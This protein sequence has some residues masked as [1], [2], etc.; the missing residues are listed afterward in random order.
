MIAIT[1][2]KVQAWLDKHDYKPVTD[3][4]LKGS[5][6][7]DID[8]RT[9]ATQVEGRQRSR[10][11]LPQWYAERH[12]LIWPARISLEQCSSEAT[13]RFK[14]SLVGGNRFADLTGGM[15]VDAFYLSQSF[16]EGYYV[17]K[18]PELFDITRHNLQSLEADVSYY[19]ADGIV[20]LSKQQEGFDWLY[21]DPARR[22][23]H[24]QKVI[25]LQDYSPDI[26]TSLSLLLQKARNIMV[27]VS[28]MAD[29]CE[30]QRQIAADMSFYVIAVDNECKEILLCF[31]ENVDRGLIHAVNITD[32]EVQ[33]EVFRMDEEG[34]SEVAYS[35]PMQ[36]LYE[37][38]V[39]IM[40]TGTFRSIGSRY[41]LHKLHENSH[42]Y[43]SE[44]LVSD[45]P[46]RIF[47]IISNVRPNRKDLK[48]ALPSGRGSL[49]V[50]NFPLGAE[51]LKKKLSLKDG[52][53]AYLFATT[54][55]DG[56]KAL[57]ITEKA[58]Q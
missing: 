56:D 17:E 19:H 22:N 52:Q 53:D 2:S 36:Y 24:K 37:P 16:Q 58:A 15:G 18:N 1:D 30:L 47:R 35:F 57:L 6:F 32:T 3:L 45:F 40:K 34:Q 38:N 42:L 20:W 23:E 51:A 29:I 50:R 7:T 55:K 21:L 39:A 10:K 44:S 48:K 31:G 12:K 49:T 14:A 9:L 27:K 43:T 13:A 26:I 28:P 33:K 8:V 25:R 11:K 5:P 4:L 54:L 46:G 41:D